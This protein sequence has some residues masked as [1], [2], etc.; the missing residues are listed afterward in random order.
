MNCIDRGPLFALEFRKEKNRTAKRARWRANEKKIINTCEPYT[1]ISMLNNRIPSAQYSN[2][3]NEWKKKNP[4]VGRMECGKEYY[5][6]RSSMHEFLTY[7]TVDINVRT[8]IHTIT[9]HIISPSAYF[10]FIALCENATN[11]MDC[12][13]EIWYPIEYQGETQTDRE[14][15][16]P[17]KFINV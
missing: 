11:S 5:A 4:N 6:A 8:P 16:Q 3:S 1:L 9:F 2:R 10:F 13:V 15:R 7:F 14:K 17:I 12:R